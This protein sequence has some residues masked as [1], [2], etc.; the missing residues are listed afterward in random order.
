M[1]LSGIDFEVAVEEERVTGEREFV[2][3]RSLEPGSVV[4]WRPGPCVPDLSI[5]LVLIG[6]D[7]CELFESDGG[8]AFSRCGE[9]TDSDSFMEEGV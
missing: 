4:D 1:S 6:S 2:P 3:S 8:E 5:E 7:R 9:V